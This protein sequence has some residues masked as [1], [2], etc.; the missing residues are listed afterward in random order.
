[1]IGFS[2]NIFQEHLK[3]EINHLVISSSSNVAY[4]YELSNYRPA[5]FPEGLQGEKNRSLL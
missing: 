5:T 4:F 2:F 1:M 3:T